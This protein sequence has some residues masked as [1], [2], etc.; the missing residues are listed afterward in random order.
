MAWQPPKPLFPTAA[1][2]S[3]LNLTGPTSSTASAATASATPPRRPLR[4][5]APSPRCAGWRATA[6]SRSSRFGYV[7]HF[8][9]GDQDVELTYTSLLFEEALHGTALS[10]HRIHEIKQYVAALR[11]L[12]R[13]DRSARGSATPSSSAATSAPKS[14]CACRPL[15]RH[16]STTASAKPATSRIGHRGRRRPGLHTR[17]GVGLQGSDRLRHRQ[18]PASRTRD[19]S[20]QG[21][22]TDGP[23]LTLQTDAAQA[24]GSTPDTRCQWRRRGGR[25]QTTATSSRSAQSGRFLVLKGITYR[26]D[27]R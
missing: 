19:Q 5:P 22:K 27:T 11:Q 2:G 7:R 10:S 6:A 17:L 12:P 14:T 8:R 15:S 9:D 26:K 24:N 20:H 18:P 1:T 3:A 21:E 16:S 4:L 25:A 23:Q 13:L